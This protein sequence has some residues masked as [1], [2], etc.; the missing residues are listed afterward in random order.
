MLFVILKGVAKYKVSYFLFSVSWLYS[1]IYLKFL[2]LSPIMIIGCRHKNF[3]VPTLK[4]PF[5]LIF[6]KIGNFEL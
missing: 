4:T 6:S 3:K 2:R 1:I 5:A